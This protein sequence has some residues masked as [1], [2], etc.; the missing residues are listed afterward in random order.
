MVEILEQGAVSFLAVPRV[1]GAVEGR[2][3]VERL[4]VVLAPEGRRPL[5]R[6]SVRRRRLP[7]AERRQRFF[8][9]VDRIAPAPGRLTEDVRA[10]ASHGHDARVLAVGR[11]ALARHSDHVHLAY[12]LARACA[13]GALA[14]SLGVAAGAS[15]VLSVFR[16]SLPPTR[17]PRTDAPLAPATPERLD[18]I[19]AEVALVA[20]GRPGDARLGLPAG[21]DH[22]GEALVSALL[23]RGP[24][25][26]VASFARASAPGTGAKTRAAGARKPSRR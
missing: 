6:I 5:R 20:G 22:V 2:N 23:R 4:F 7:D 12:A 17:R 18:V 11:Y 19:G 13:R 8:A 3:A 10:P 9:H 24:R 14:Q 15:F 1:G 26:R 25:P 21:R 16:R